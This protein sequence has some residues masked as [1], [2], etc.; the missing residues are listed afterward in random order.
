MPCF[1]FQARYFVS[2]VSSKS[3]LTHFKFDEQAE[4][5]Q[6]VELQPASPDSYFNYRSYQSDK[7]HGDTEHVT[8]RIDN[9]HSNAEQGRVYR[10]ARIPTDAP[11]LWTISLAGQRTIR[12]TASSMSAR[13]AGEIR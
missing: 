9:Q 11:W 13:R 5:L 3:L 1:T 4:W 6:A 12:P 7:V 10:Q 2:L 8:V